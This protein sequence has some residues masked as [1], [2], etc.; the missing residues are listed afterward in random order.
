MAVF[1]SPVGGAAA[2]FFDNSGNVLTG[3]KIYTYAA[4]TT[5][6]AATYTSNTGVT[7]HSNPIILDA[8]G[9][10]PGGE[11]WLTD[12][13]QYKF[14][15][16]DANEVLIG[17]YDNIIGINSDFVNYNVQKQ[18]F[19]ATQSQT[20]FT[21]TTITYTPG[22]ST[23]N[24]Y[25]NGSKQILTT[26][27]IE[28]NST[29]VTFVSGLN[30]GDVVEFTTSAILSVGVTDSSLVIYTPAGSGAVNTT[31]QAKLRESISVLDFGA[32]KT[33]ATN[34]TTAFT[35]AWAFANPQ[36]VFVPKGSYAITGT[37]TGKFYSLGTVTITS[38][39]VTSITNLVP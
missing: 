27:Y 21:L 10:V 33:G 29:T 20:V 9:R 13:V 37:V 1:L 38:G 36:A 23:L 25:V 18:V 22:T 8:A 32:D 30:V 12:S 39:T 11:I 28:T 26:N 15:V 24:V 2:Q 35:N 5:T 7:F 4:G 3:G 17:T 6:P 16:K 34:S 14:V 19:S 31:V